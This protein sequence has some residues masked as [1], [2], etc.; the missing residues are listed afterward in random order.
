MT[1]D[2]AAIRH[3]IAAHP[4]IYI[5]TGRYIVT[6]TI[7]LKLDS[8]LIGLNPATT[9]FYIPDLTPAFQG[10]GSPNRLLEAPKNGT[11][12]VSGIGPYTNGINRRAFAAKRMPGRDSLSDDLRFLRRHAT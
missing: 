8:K 11:N 10:P 3:A 5:P 7:T 2:T 9:L 1:D 12:I 4:V 6:D